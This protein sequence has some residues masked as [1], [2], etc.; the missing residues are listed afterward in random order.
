MRPLDDSPENNYNDNEDEEP[1]DDNNGNNSEDED[2]HSFRSKRGRGGGGYGG[3]R[4]GPRD[5]YD[6]YDDYN[7]NYGGPPGGGFPPAHRGGFPPSRGFPPFRGGGRG[8]GG[9]GGFPPNGGRGRGGPRGG[10][11]DYNDMGNGWGGGP[12]GWGGPM[13]GMMGPPPG[14]GPPPHMMMGPNGFGYGGPPG[15]GGPNGP[16]PLMSAPVNMPPPGMM[17]G[18]PNMGMPPPNIGMPPPNM[19]PANPLD[20]N[21]EVWVE[22]KS[23]EGK[24]YY[25]NARTR[26]TTWTKP[27]GPNVKIILQEQ[28]EMMASQVMPTGGMPP[29]MG[30]GMPGIGG[31]APNMGPG[32]MPAGNMPDGQQSGG[33]MD[34]TESG[35][36]EG[37]KARSSSPSQSNTQA[38][39]TATGADGP[40]PNNTSNLPPNMQPPPSAAGGFPPFNPA[41][42]SG[43]PPFG[44][45]PPNF[46][47]GPWGMP[48]P[49]M[50]GMMNQQPPNTVPPVAAAAP[51]ISAPAALTKD[52]ATPKI[53]PEIVAKAAEWS[54]HKAPD[55]RSYFYNAKAGES[56][57]EKPQAM[58]DLETAKL[59]LAQGISTAV[60]SSSLAPSSGGVPATSGIAMTTDDTSQDVAKSS[61]SDSSSDSEDE[62]AKEAERKRKE[63]EEER[64]R[65]RKEEEEAKAAQ[66]RSKPV[67]STPVPGTPWCVVWTGDGRVF[68]YNPSSRTSVWERPE[69]LVSRTDV[70]KMLSS[71]PDNVVVTPPTT[72]S[73]STDNKAVKRDGGEDT[74]GEIPAK[75]SKVEVKPLS[76]LQQQH[77]AP[78]AAVVNIQPAPPQKEEIKKIDLGKEAAMEAEVRAA[79]ERAIVP[80]EQRIQSF[81]T[82]LQ[83]KDV[84]AFSTWE[85][86]LH[87]IV[88]DP[89]YLL[90]TSKERKQVFEKYVKE[91]A[92]EERKEKRNKMKERKDEYRKLMEEANLHGK[93]SF[94]DFSGKFGKDDRFKNIEKMR[95][96]ESLFNEFIIDV[97]R[98]EKEEKIVKREQIPRTGSRSHG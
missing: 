44:M 29:N 42:F 61:D 70:D 40:P 56:V 74:N 15:M 59:A 53:D 51:S 81:R 76:Q 19:G 17:G 36:G 26:E 9:R 6:D 27:E 87:K 75:K 20:L 72:S 2:D 31:V 88:F 93:S 7:D 92:E 54:E 47:Q 28:V 98:R 25:Y 89:R 94:S 55:G 43:P 23:G 80:L 21:G 69:D 49:M 8:R 68:F 14:M 71:P 38:P 79:R 77:P 5:D 34:K 65:K 48:P 62:E 12:D 52:D 73:S 33:G 22:T 11:D 64:E 95:E 45:P 60:S 3:P 97:R 32:S 96:R 83:E 46:A 41:S 57:W 18:P 24:S 39:A 58:K 84:S 78:V 66:D 13:G 91:R 63:E 4:R 37:D 82:M 50:G 30:G 1:Q 90:L 35:R 10:F 67:S 85:K 16:P 86:E